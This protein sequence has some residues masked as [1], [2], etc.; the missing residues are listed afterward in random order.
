[1]RTKS[2][3]AAAVAFACGTLVAPGCRTAPKAP[4]ASATASAPARSA[5]TIGTITGRVE[6]VDPSANTIQ[7][8]GQTLKTDGATSVKKGGGNVILADVKEGDEVRVD[9][10]GSGDA[11]KVVRIEVMSPAATSGAAPTDGAQRPDG[12][13]GPIHRF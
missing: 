6:R 4:P 1:M 12:A 3:W 10:S 7:V 11:V 5:E 9:L 2:S 8:A 13:R